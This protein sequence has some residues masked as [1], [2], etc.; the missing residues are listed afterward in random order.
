MKLVIPTGL[1][2]L[3][4]TYLQNT[5]ALAWR[6]KATLK[7]AGR[8]DFNRLPRSTMRTMRGHLERVT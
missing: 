8:S 5:P 3:S 7:D 6:K 1:D 4:A 2:R